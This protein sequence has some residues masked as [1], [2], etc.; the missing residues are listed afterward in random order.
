[1]QFPEDYPTEDLCSVYER[2]YSHAMYQKRMQAEDRL[3][4]SRYQTGNNRISKTK[5]EQIGNRLYREH[6][7]RERRHTAQVLAVNLKE[8][9]KR[10][11]TKITNKTQQLVQE[12]LIKDIEKVIDY[13]D[14]EGSG[15]FTIR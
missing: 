10:E 7:E 1:M 14:V 13:V 3:A 4:A 6:V 15:Y 12:K 11:K 8:Q 9:M 2:L 5:G